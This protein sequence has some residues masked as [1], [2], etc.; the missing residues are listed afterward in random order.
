MMV[1]NS[2]NPLRSCQKIALVLFRAIFSEISPINFPHDLFYPIKIKSIKKIK[3]LKTC[4]L[5]LITKPFVFVTKLSKFRNQTKHVFLPFL[6]GLLLEIYFE[7]YS[8][9]AHMWRN[10]IQIN[11]NAFK[12]V[13]RPLGQAAIL[14]FPQIKFDLH[15]YSIFKLNNIAIAHQ[16]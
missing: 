14:S 7:V 12:R 13:L 5:F 6:L 15:G 16:I 8:T 2:S 1:A 11:V 4:F 9:C 10:V 3:L